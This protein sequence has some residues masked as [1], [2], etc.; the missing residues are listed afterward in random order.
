MK[1]KLQKDL[2][3]AMKAHNKQI[4]DVIKLVK[5]TIQNEEIKLK[6]E[7]SDDEVLSIITKQV[8]MRKDAIVDFEK[9]GREDLINQYNEEIKILNEYLPKELTIEEVKTIIEDAINIVKPEGIKDMGKIMKEISPKLKNR[10]DMSKVSELIK[11]K[12]A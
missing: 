12:L 7:L 5:A 8:K 2:I 3:D 1:E 4:I 6:K 9:A 10:F 11:E